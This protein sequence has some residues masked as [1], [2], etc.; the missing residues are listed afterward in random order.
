MRRLTAVTAVLA[1]LLAMPVLAHAE[2]LSG[3]EWVL[4]GQSGQGAPFLRFEAGRVGGSGGCNGFGAS[5]KQSGSSLSFSPIAATRMAC[6][7]NAMETE[8]AFFAMLEQVK[9]MK[10]D[11]DTLQLLD[12][13]GQ[14]IAT[15]TRRMGQ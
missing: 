5:Y 12:G 13:K 6:A 9:G 10:L 1:G 3:G 14:V 11:G 7:G 2:K 15:L 4:A 8:H